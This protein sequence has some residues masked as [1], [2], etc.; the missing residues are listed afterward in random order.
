MD[1]YSIN[2]LLDSETSFDLLE[3][4]EE[5]NF[6]LLLV[7]PVNLDYYSFLRASSLP[8]FEDAACLL[9]I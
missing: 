8:V 7:F 4:L 9:W 6:Y 5:V 2:L 3:L 1:D